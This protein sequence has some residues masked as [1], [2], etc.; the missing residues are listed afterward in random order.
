MDVL[1]GRSIT[2]VGGG[3]M[4][5]AL[6]DALTK[7]GVSVVGPVRRNEPIRGD[8]VLLTVPDREIPAAVA[9][10][11]LEAMVGHTAG[12][13]TLAALAPHEAFSFHPLM[14]ASHGRA[15]FAAASAAGAGSTPRALEIARTP[16]RHLSIQPLAIPDSQ[17]A[18]YH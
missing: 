8:L 2:I 17:R 9:G 10:A 6:I 7:A 13:V 1:G 15:I 16:S 18:A 4:G 14:T 5:S 11:P 12:A 3:R